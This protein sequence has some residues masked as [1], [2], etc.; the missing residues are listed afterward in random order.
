MRR[1]YWGD[2]IAHGHGHA[3]HG[4][5]LPGVHLPVRR[6][7]QVE[8]GLPGR[9]R[10][11]AQPPV[12]AALGE[13]AP[14]VAVFAQEQAARLLV[15]AEEGGGGE[16]DGQYL[17]GGHLCLGVIFVTPGA[18]EVVAQAVNRDDLSNLVSHGRPPGQ[19]WVVLPLYR[20]ARPCTPSKKR[21]LGYL[22]YRGASHG[23]PRGKH[24]ALFPDRVN[25]PP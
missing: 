23:S 16:R 14:D 22:S 2:V 21:N 10:H 8:Q 24:P 4:V 3:V 19:W 1:F 20:K 12:Q 25:K 11:G 7:E 17:R 18:K 5:P 9:L 13:H 15:A 6:G